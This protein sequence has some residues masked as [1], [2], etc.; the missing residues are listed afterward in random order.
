VI[1]ALNDA[2]EITNTNAPAL[3]RGGL[4]IY[5]L[6][7]QAMYE[8]TNYGRL[9]FAQVGWAG[10][11]NDFIGTIEQLLSNVTTISGT[12][13]WAGHTLILIHT[14]SWIHRTACIS[15]AFSGTGVY[16][17]RLHNAIPAQWHIRGIYRKPGMTLI[18]T[19]Q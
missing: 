8:E 18:M 11:L 7:G 3:P 14:H 15:M 2:I 5:S 13:T 16:K 17:R 6:T 19:D 9:A 1:A 12:I 10:F 4:T